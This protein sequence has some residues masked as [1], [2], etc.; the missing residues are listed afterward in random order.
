MNIRPSILT[1]IHK[2]SAMFGVRFT[3]A[4]KFFAADLKKVSPGRTLWETMEL[5]E[6]I[7]KWH[8]TIGEPHG[9]GKHV[10]SITAEIGIAGSVPKPIRDDGQ[11]DLFGGVPA[12]PQVAPTDG[13]APSG[14]VSAAE[15][16]PGGSGADQGLDLEAPA[17]S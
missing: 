14:G 17:G 11:G 6:A 13:S 1:A 10:L 4:G 7:R 16:D 8:D 3:Y 2:V 9:Q 15:N 12:G 5:E